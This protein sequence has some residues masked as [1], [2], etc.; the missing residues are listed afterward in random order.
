MIIED[1]IEDD[2]MLAKLL[3][4]DAVLVDRKHLYGVKESISGL[5]DLR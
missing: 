4:A 2:F 1:N 3:G 5:G